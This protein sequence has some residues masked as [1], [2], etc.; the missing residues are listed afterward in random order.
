MKLRNR[1]NLRAFPDLITSKSIGYHKFVFYYGQLLVFNKKLTGT[2]CSKFPWLLFENIQMNKFSETVLFEHL[3]NNPFFLSGSFC[4]WPPK[5]VNFAVSQCT[6]INFN[7]F[8]K[9]LN[10]AP[11]FF[12]NVRQN[13]DSPA[14]C[15][16]LW[17]KFTTPFFVKAFF[18]QQTGGKRGFEPRFR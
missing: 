12:G 11:Q 18:S 14:I 6:W 2:C 5:V 3:I 15:S 13:C 9:S 1:S 4:L 7:N 10:V 17:D 16:T 8:F